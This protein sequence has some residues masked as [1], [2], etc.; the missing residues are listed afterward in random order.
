MSVLAH[1]AEMCAPMFLIVALGYLFTRAW[2]C[3][4]KLSDA[5]SQVVFTIAL[6]ALLFGLM[7]DLSRLPPVDLRVLAAFFGSCLLVFGIARHIGWWL[8]KL[9]GVS[10]SLFALAAIFSNNAL[11]GIPLAKATLGDAAMPTVALVLVFNS[12]TLWT[13]VT[14]SVEWARQ[15]S[16]TLTGFGATLKGVLKNPLII[17]I[18]SGTLVG[19]MGWRLPNMIKEPLHWVGI[20]AAPLALFTLG[21][22]LAEHGIKAHWK[23]SLSMTALK[24]L[25]QP[26]VVWLLARAMGLPATE[27]S[28]VVLLGSVAVG[29]NVYLM[30]RHF[31][32]LEGPVAAS[33]VLSTA[34]SALTTPLIL[35]LLSHTH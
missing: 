8:F 17:A 21:M 24:L 30:S 2:R 23:L 19:L 1:Y 6:P 10:Q 28:A 13:L 32:V 4:R 12:L 9:D 35:A 7:S 25:L 34:G 18:L 27:T 14:V 26:L 20:A 15:G 33:L 29:A 22:G 5:L 31:R 16:P 3:P 11:L